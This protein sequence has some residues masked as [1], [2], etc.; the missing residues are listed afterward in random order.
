MNCAE[1]VRLVAIADVRALRDRPEVMQHCLECGDCAALVQSISHETEE[2]SS[3]YDAIPSGID[4]YLVSRR[5]MAEA[6]L[7]RRRRLWQ[8]RA[9]TAAV[10]VAFVSLFAMRSSIR[11][12]DGSMRDMRTFELR[13]LDEHQAAALI[14]PMLERTREVDV[15]ILPVVDGVRAITVRGNEQDLDRVEQIIARFDNAR[16]TSTNPSC[17]SR[18]PPIGTT[19]PTPSA[20]VPSPRTIAPAPTPA[21]TPARLSPLAPLR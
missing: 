13:C 4:P 20:D 1:C 3:L 18:E 17:P 19:V 10:L 5:A 6:A 21:P 14:G 15:V 12:A 8:V 2:M 16:V 7:R 9:A 11:P